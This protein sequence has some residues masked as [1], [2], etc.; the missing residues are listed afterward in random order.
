MIRLLLAFA[1]FV[2]PVWAQEGRPVGP[3]PTATGQAATGQIPGTLTNDSASASNV[4]EIISSNGDGN[5]TTATITIASPAVVTMAGHVLNGIA[6]VVFT[7]SGA[8]PT[9]ITAG[10]TYYTGPSTTAGNTFNIATTVANASAGTFINTSGSQSGTQ[11]G[12]GAVVLVT[13]TSIDVGGVSLTAG[14][15]QV[16]VKA[17]YATAISTITTGADVSLSTTSSTRGTGTGIFGLARYTPN[18]TGNGNSVTALAGPIN[19]KISTPTTYFAV[20]RSVFTTSTASYSNGG[21]YAI[22]VR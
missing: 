20:F 16:W 6:A 5:S 1:L 10:T 4:G 22:R 3:N 17:D 18:T 21:I 11:T 14:N 19:I 8:L 9:G 2:T 12:T 7:T 15:W 13:N